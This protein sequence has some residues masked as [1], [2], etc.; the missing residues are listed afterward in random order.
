[1]SLLDN[2]LKKKNISCY[3]ELTE[4]EKKVYDEY[5][6]ALNVPEIKVEDIES[7]VRQ[8]LNILSNDIINFSNS[9]KKDTF[10]KAQM[11]VLRIILAFIT[12]DLEVKKMVEEKL[13][14]ELN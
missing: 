5:E 4:D 14:K 9:E 12:K 2:W 13:K 11:S 3:D 10:I 8:Q 6:K 7:F 1:M